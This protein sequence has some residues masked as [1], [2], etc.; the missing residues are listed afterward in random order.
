V[1]CGRG[2]PFQ[3]VG[4]DWGYSL[5]LTRT[6]HNDSIPETPSGKSGVDVST[7]VHPVAMPLD[8]P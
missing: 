8:G 3:V 6:L 5:K 4:R 2:V 7:A 1:E